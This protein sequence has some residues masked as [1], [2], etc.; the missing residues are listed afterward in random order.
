VKLSPDAHLLAYVSSENGAKEVYVTAAG[1][2]A[3]AK[4]MASRGGGS[5]VQWRPDGSEL[6]Y[7]SADGHGMVSV[8]VKSDNPVNLGE[9]VKLFDLPEGIASWD[10]MGNTFDVSADGQRILMIRNARDE[11]MG[12]TPFPS[13]V[14]VLNWFTEFGQQP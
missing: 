2:I 13:A 4:T 5:H 10:V 12:P 7:L 6:F 1:A 9:P 8:A 3:S 14:V 11:N